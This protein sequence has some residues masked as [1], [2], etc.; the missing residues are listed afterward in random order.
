VHRHHVEAL[1]AEEVAALQAD[2]AAGTIAR[3]EQRGT[4][5]VVELRRATYETARTGMV[6]GFVVPLLDRRR[7]AMLVAR[8]DCDNYDTDPVSVAFTKD[9]AA[10]TELPFEDWPKGRGIVQQHHETGKPF[11]CRPGVREFHAH[12]Q[13]GDEPWD[14]LRGKLLIRHL[15]RSLADDLLRKQVL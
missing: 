11:V 10:T 3:L 6:G 14:L 1:I 12:I 13:H 5:L 7:E 2:V 4:I 15:V 9:W 8:L